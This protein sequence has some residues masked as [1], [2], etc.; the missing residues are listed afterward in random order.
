MLKSYHRLPS[1]RADLLVKLGRLDQARAEF[2]RAASLTGNSRDREL[3]LER[4]A[5][6]AS[7]TGAS[8]QQ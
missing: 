8:K 1:A 7:G 4:A 6:C 5:G 2:E 3:L